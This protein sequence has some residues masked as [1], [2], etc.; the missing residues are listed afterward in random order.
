MQE[1]PPLVSIIVIT[2]N[3]AK[4]VLETLESAK[5]QTYQNIE[6]IV[7]DDCSIDNTVEICM[8][9][10]EEN[11]E[12][13]VRTELITTDKNSG[14]PANC[15]RG[16]KAA[17]GEW[18]K[19]IAG[20]DAMFF[21]AI[22]NVIEFI[23]DKPHI[24][25]LLTQVEVFLSEFIIENSNG[26]KPID[27]NTSRVYSATATPKIQLEYILRGGYY[28]AP[29]LFIKKSIFSEIGYFD[30]LYRLNE[31]IP[32]YLSLAINNKLI[33]FTP[34]KTVKYRKHKDSLTTVNDR[35]LPIYMSQTYTAIYKAS[36]KYKD[37]IYI[38]NSM[39]HLMLI[40]LIFKLGNI[41]WLC[42]K[43]NDIRN[44]LQPIRLL[45]FK[46]IFEKLFKQTPLI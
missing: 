44:T 20:D 5:A 42:K 45:W 6:L 8:E 41:G 33:Y 10:I 1:K 37:V 16:Y 38:I 27:W 24:E 46:R 19:G 39:W 28:Y 18:Y 22:E 32:F 23:K 40:K 21:N 13:F 3:S 31:D 14:I 43:I 4:Y 36:I 11:K 34:I 26:I 29:G 35:I 7:S 2:Y 30:E 12:R 25:V 9:W 15:N 17:Q